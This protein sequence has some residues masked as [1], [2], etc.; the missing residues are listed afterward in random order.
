MKNYGIYATDNY[1]PTSDEPPESGTAQQTMC[2]VGQQGS[3]PALKLK[4]TFSAASF[5]CA[6]AYA[7]GYE[8]G[9]KEGR[10]S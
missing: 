5:E 2:E 8:E 3:D 10:F 1:D 4:H 9:F 7:E 6:L